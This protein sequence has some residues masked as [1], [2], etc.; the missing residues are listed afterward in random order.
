MYT[1]EI[2]AQDVPVPSRSMTD[3]EV[4]EWTRYI[5]SLSPADQMRKFGQALD[6]LYAMVEKSGNDPLALSEKD[7]SA[8][9]AKDDAAGITA[10][11]GPN[12]FYHYFSSP[13]EAEKRSSDIERTIISI[14][15]FLKSVSSPEAKTWE[16][17][18]V[19]QPKIET[20]MDPIDQKQEDKWM[21]ATSTP[22]G[23]GI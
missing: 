2:A 7:Q 6:Q 11:N 10:V 15:N 13:K 18:L 9:I 12:W 20:F 22:N 21:K 4:N 3:E 14:A 19:R 1:W 8:L 17:R 5:G 23:P 16:D